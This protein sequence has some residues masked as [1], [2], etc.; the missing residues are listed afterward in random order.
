MKDVR[1][2]PNL[3][4]L[5][6]SKVLHRSMGY[7]GRESAHGHTH[8]TPT[9]GIIA[10]ATDSK[11]NEYLDGWC[12]TA[13]DSD[14]AHAD[15]KLTKTADPTESELC[16]LLENRLRDVQ[17]TDAQTSAIRAKLA[18]LG[19]KAYDSRYDFIQQ[20]HYRLGHRGIGDLITFLRLRN[21]KLS[22]IDQIWCRAC[23]L[24]K[25]KQRDYAT[26]TKRPALAR[27]VRPAGSKW[28]MD[29]VGP[30]PK[31]VRGY[32]YIWT[33][34]NDDSKR[35]LAIPTATLAN[36]KTTSTAFLRHMQQELQD[37]G[38]T[39]AE[40]QLTLHCSRL[41]GDH[42]RYFTSE[43]NTIDFSTAGIQIIFSAPYTPT[44]NPYVERFH[45]TL[46][47][48]AFAMLYH[49]NA[50]LD[51]WCYA[52][53]HAVN[54]YHILPHSSLP[55][56]HSP[57][58][59]ATGLIPDH[60]WL[61]IHWS[62][63]AV[64]IPSPQRNKGQPKCMFGRWIGYEYA[65]RT[66]LILIPSGHGWKLRK[67]AHVRIDTA[68]RPAQPKDL[69]LPDTI[70]YDTDQHHEQDA[71]VTTTSPHT[72]TVPLT[73]GWLR[74]L[75]AAGNNSGYKHPDTGN[76]TSV[77]PT[78]E[79]LQPQQ[80]QHN[81]NGITCETCTKPLPTSRRDK[82]ERYCLTCERTQHIQAKQNNSSPTPTT[83][84]TTTCTSKHC[85]NM[86]ST[87]RQQQGETTCASCAQHNTYASMTNTHQPTVTFNTEEDSNQGVPPQADTNP[88]ED[89]N[90]GVSPQAD[91]NPPADSN[92]GVQPSAPNR[93]TRSQTR[94]SR[95]QYNQRLADK[96][97]T[98]TP[99]PTPHNKTPTE[100]IDSI[101]KVLHNTLPRYIRRYYSLCKQKHR[102]DP[103]IQVLADP[104][105]DNNDEIVRLATHMGALH[106]LGE[107]HATPTD[108]LKRASTQSTDWA[109]R[110]FY[111][112]RQ[113]QHP[114][115]PYRH[116]MPA[117]RDKEL[118]ALLQ[119]GH[120]KRRPALVIVERADLPPNAKIGK[121][122]TIY[123]YKTD[124]NSKVT[125]GKLRVAYNGAA[126]KLLPDQ[127]DSYSNIS[128]TNNIRTVL[129]TT[130][131]HPAN[132]STHIA[133]IP[134]AYLWANNTKEEYC[135]LPIDLHPPDSSGKPCVARI[136]G[137]L[138]GRVDSG[139]LF[140]RKRD[141]FLTT[142]CG[143]TQCTLD[144]SIF[145][146]LHND[147]TV[148]AVV[149]DLLWRGRTE[150]CKRFSN[151]LTKEFGDCGEQ[152]ITDQW[153]KY[154]GVML[155][156]KNNRYEWSSGRA[157]R[158]ALDRYHYINIKES[159]LPATPG[160]YTSKYDRAPESETDND[161]PSRTKQYQRRQGG[162]QWLVTTGRF[163]IA[164]AVKHSASVMASPKPT[165]VQLHNKLYGYLKRTQDII[166]TW[167]PERSPVPNNQLYYHTD[168]SYTGEGLQ[169]RMGFVGSVNGG[170]VIADN[171]TT[172]FQCTGVFDVEEAAACWGAKDAVYRRALLTELGYPQGPTII[173]CDN[174]AT[175]LFSK[176]T[177][178]TSLNK[179]V[180]VRGMYTR[181]LQ[182]RGI[183]QLRGI[184][185][186]D[187]VADQQTKHLTD[188][189]F[190]DYLPEYGFINIPY[191]ASV[192]RL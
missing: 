101:R 71:G 154:L 130:P 179:H 144:P 120:N 100:T 66:H 20:L 18:A 37:H 131:K 122:L 35:A 36:F 176:R 106:W 148:I 69:K 187:N 64:Y 59:H 40:I 77:P 50:P 28:S 105:S 119:P 16:N 180:A 23:L 76:T 123:S 121:L 42:A 103:V 13:E 12:V 117:A 26:L 155:R 27:I 21:I 181:E 160:T 19:T 48:S 62:L 188:H 29:A 99:P 110:T 186:C 174:A 8:T 58:Q 114:S 44:S 128:P 140:E 70:V 138:Y 189:L 91:S 95:I 46:L 166:L 150:S 94:S 102:P 170:T 47:T 151:Q 88:P 98:T 145:Y 162:L 143:L 30:L 61:H 135:E 49:A 86:V 90:Q 33:L 185:G 175:V 146:D 60:D 139:H 172:K 152:Q 82:G 167:N 134:T 54:V 45:Q 38:L 4:S 92:Q 129:S 173:Y 51:T 137:A 56:K 57:L 153:R 5:T 41:R 1:F 24:A 141:K 9:G 178:I 83:L 89:S 147:V 127:P 165:H 17:F 65:S 6:N 31:S 182:Q 2:H 84:T 177:L 164:L 43:G 156:F 87:G 79:Q 111:N 169:S 96:V 34:I 74:V 22:K 39:H 184:A 157:V 85:N 63:A 14:T 149:D 68:I 112:Y 32:R 93:I 53:E 142:T 108:Q 15:I 72:I 78:L 171:S 104:D 133:D 107:H 67:S 52:V 124:G 191:P 190:Y 3:E 132:H 109:N 97:N 161:Q 126:D 118:R 75:D 113:T 55:N 11:Q 116:L 159:K 115:N 73:N 168:G 25:M 183:I 163:D 10:A 125:K 80:P 81:I 192:T 7:I 158:E 136:D